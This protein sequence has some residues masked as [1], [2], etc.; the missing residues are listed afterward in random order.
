MNW[1]RI[2]YLTHNQATAE[3]ISRRFPREIV[4]AV[5]MASIM[6][7]RGDVVVVQPLPPGAT[8]QERERYDDFLDH[9]RTKVSTAFVP[10]II[11]EIE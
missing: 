7:R 3:S 5:P 4:D 9:A 1:P 10:L 2:L 8:D 6:G 11:G